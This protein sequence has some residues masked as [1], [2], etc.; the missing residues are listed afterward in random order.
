MGLVKLPTKIQLQEV[1]RL[2]IGAGECPK[3]GYVHLDAR[4]LPCI[5]IVCDFIALPFENNQLEEIISSQV[6]EHIPKWSRR[7]TLVE[8]LRVLKPGGFLRLD[9]P[10][11]DG[12]IDHYVKAR[13]KR[14]DINYQ[15]FIDR[16]YGGQD[17]K[18]NTHY[19]TYTEESLKDE[20]I[21][22]GFDAV[23]PLEESCWTDLH[24][25]AFK[26]RSIDEQASE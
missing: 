3:E 8:W 11:L 14:I 20:L 5:E 2:E 1:S 24:V 19:V 10:N 12:W 4:E 26:R 18:E 22:A 9:T 15:D 7:A 25:I 23:E 13:D 6:I 17:Y 21:K 16:L